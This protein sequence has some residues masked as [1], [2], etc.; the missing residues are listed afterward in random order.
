NK[1]LN[2][3]FT[4]LKTK[5]LER[6]TSANFSIIIKEIQKFIINSQELKYYQKNI[7]IN[8]IETW[9]LM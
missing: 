3:T 2:F 5:I 4:I 8:Q 1:K 9:Y 6:L 7:Y